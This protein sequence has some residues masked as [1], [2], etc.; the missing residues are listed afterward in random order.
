MRLA[1]SA[2]TA[3]S[4]LVLLGL[5]IYGQPAAYVQDAQ[6]RLDAW[7]K[8][9]P[10]A[11]SAQTPPQDEKL[12]R[13]MAQLQQEI[14]NL[15]ARLAESQAPPPPAEPQAVAPIVQ[16][17]P[18]QQQTATT[19]DIVRRSPPA[20]HPVAMAPVPPPV[21]DT[22]ASHAERRAVAGAPP[23]PPAE[24]LPPAS[25]ATPAT[26]SPAAPLAAPPAAVIPPAPPVAS[27]AKSRTA[28]LPVHVPERREFTGQSRSQ[29]KRTTPDAGSGA[30]N[31]A[32]AVPP[33]TAPPARVAVA[34]PV[35]PL[36]LPP[37]RPETDDSQS[38]LARLR[39]AGP[40]PL[41]VPRPA[42]N[43]PPATSPA[44]PRLTAARSALASGHTDDAVRLL[45]EAQ[46][47]LVF[48]PIDAPGADPEATGQGASDVARALEAL[49]ANNI[50]AS[51]RYIDRAMADLNGI[52]TTPSAAFPG[53]GATGYAPAYP[54]R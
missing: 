23:P 25:P 31:N 5:A 42:E 21:A 26:T 13:R 38:V 15:Q 36:V 4:G 19:P 49:S 6:D 16:P 9:A 18:A 11:P 43:R 52:K 44:L 53:S 30:S 50:P 12:A 2:A 10:A 51:R 7:L 41:P 35:P 40:Q 45:Q 22:T 47:Q 24:A 54:P 33:R 46:L 27:Q 28:D 48:R 32:D 34:R 1:F 17:P 37:P 8:P 39:Q 3:L 29:S 14:S 20:A